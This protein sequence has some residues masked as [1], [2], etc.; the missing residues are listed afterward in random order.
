L[1]DIRKPRWLAN[2]LGRRKMNRLISRKP[3][4]ADAS[5]QQLIHTMK[6][7]FSERPGEVKKIRA[8]MKKEG[9]GL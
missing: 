3:A 5:D 8:A 4:G 9:C 2:W 1:L 7:W 6:A